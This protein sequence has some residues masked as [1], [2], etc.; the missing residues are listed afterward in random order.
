[1]ANADGQRVQQSWDNLRERLEKM[2]HR[3]KNLPCLKIS[4]LPKQRHASENTQNVSEL[5]EDIPEL[6]GEEFP[7]ELNV[8]DFETE[9]MV[10]MDVVLWTE[11]K[12]R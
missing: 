7:A 1:M 11:S 9:V 12:L 5:D 6:E 4:E 10:G 3:Q 8:G 2:P